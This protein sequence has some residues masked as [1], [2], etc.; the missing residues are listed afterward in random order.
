MDAEFGPAAMP[1]EE[2]A[3]IEQILENVF[4]QEQNGRAF[5]EALLRHRTWAGVYEQVCALSLY[6]RTS[7]YGSQLKSS[8]RSDATQGSTL[9]YFAAWAHW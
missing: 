4:A 5:I 8:L 3:A 2:R 1:G 9:H 7:S 6:L